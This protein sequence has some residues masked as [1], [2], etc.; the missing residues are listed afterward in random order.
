MKKILGD[1]V[2]VLKYF[3]LYFLVTNLSF[4]TLALKKLEHHKY[5]SQF[6][7]KYLETRTEWSLV[8]VNDDSSVDFMLFLHQSRCCGRP[9]ACFD[10]SAV[11]QTFTIHWRSTKKHEQA[12][13]L[14]CIMQENIFSKTRY[15]LSVERYEQ[16]NM[17]KQSS[18][19]LLPTANWRWKGRDEKI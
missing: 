19:D 7:S 17:K 13:T 3:G 1:E 8:R 15:I 18:N 9:S 12:F 16:W 5:F 10:S 2:P 4:P 6:S 11:P 14:L